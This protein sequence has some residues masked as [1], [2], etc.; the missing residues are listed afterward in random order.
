M[1]DNI[2]A[3][4]NT[5]FLHIKKSKVVSRF[6]WSF[7]RSTEPCLWIAAGNLDKSIDY[8]QAFKPRKSHRKLGIIEPHMSHMIRRPV[9]NEFGW[10]NQI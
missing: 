4:K 2:D 7:I 10:K 6:G 8:F 5:H 3:V 9:G 1:Y